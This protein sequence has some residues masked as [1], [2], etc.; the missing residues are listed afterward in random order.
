MKES[1]GKKGL[2]PVIA[3]VMMILLVLVLASIIFLWARGF[4]GEHIEKFGKP[5]EDYCGN[6]KFEMHR[7]GL[8]LEVVNKGNVDIRSLNIKM[9]KDGD[10]EVNNFNFQID[11]GDSESGYIS[12]EMSDGSIPDEII[13]YPALIGEVQGGGSNSVFTCLDAGVT[14]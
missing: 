12:F 7:S 4:I 3:S 5:I 6:V 13:A 2:S 8:N 10:S 14:L 11:A 1:L 9:I